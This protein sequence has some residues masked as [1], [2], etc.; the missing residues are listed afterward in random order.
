VYS[1]APVDRP[2][3][4]RLFAVSDSQWKITRLPNMC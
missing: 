3:K 2:L 4:M 1:Q